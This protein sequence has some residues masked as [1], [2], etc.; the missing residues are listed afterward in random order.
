MYAYVLHGILFLILFFLIDEWS[1]PS[2][3]LSQESAIYGQVME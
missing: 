2:G 1:V 3:H